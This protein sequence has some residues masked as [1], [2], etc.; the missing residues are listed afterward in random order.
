MFLN[1]FKFKDSTL[2]FFNG[3]NRSFDNNWLPFFFGFVDFELL[4][5]VENLIYVFSRT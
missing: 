1:F 3:P 4:M 5:K 2:Q